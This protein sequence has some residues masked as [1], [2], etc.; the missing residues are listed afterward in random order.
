MIHTFKNKRKTKVNEFE[1]NGRPSIKQQ[2]EILKLI[3]L[4]VTFT[5]L[6]SGF[7]AYSL[8]WWG[9]NSAV[10]SAALSPVLVFLSVWSIKIAFLAVKGEAP[11]LT[12]F[13]AKLIAT[14]VVVLGVAS[15][16]GALLG[17]VTA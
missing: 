9:T 12:A 3:S 10:G 14:G 6:T 15:L 7:I 13:T 4:A 17:Y 2:A 1:H 16:A 5:T 11:F 8:K